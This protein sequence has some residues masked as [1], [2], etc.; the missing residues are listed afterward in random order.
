MIKN[1][2]KK[3]ERFKFK[4]FLTLLT[5]PLILMQLIDLIQT[6]LQ[7][8]TQIDFDLVSYRGNDNKIP[9]NLSPAVMVCFEFLFD[10]IIFHQENLKYTALMTENKNI[11][12]LD[13][14]NNNKTNADNQ[15]N[16]HLAI[17]VILSGIDKSSEEIFPLKS[18]SPLRQIA[19]DHVQSIIKFKNKE[20]FEENYELTHNK[21]ISGFDHIFKDFE[22]FK[23]IIKYTDYG[24]EESKSNSSEIPLI[25]PFGQ[26]ISYYKGQHN[27]SNV[28]IDQIV[29]DIFLNLQNI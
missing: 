20:E 22:I 11:S 2:L 6:Y 9:I 27:L 25:T 8:S 18:D 26:C 10:K 4:L 16:Y 21:N 1:F 3:L 24:L 23:S 29:P 14:I 13:I 28:K 5:F 15:T 17:E 7:F 12:L 19:Y